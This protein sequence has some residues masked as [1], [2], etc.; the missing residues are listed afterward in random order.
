M[1]KWRTIAVL[2]PMNDLRPSS[3][4]PVLDPGTV[5]CAECGRVVEED[6]AQAQRWGHWS[7]GVGELYPYCAKCADRECGKERLERTLPGTS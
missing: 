1:Q 7:D 2:P 5:T 3:D 4:G 6:E